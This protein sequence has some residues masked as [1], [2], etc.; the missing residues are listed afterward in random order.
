MSMFCPL[1]NLNIELLMTLKKQA[2]A[3]GEYPV[4]LQHL[5]LHFIQMNETETT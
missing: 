5:P 1:S 4:K 3:G 2:S